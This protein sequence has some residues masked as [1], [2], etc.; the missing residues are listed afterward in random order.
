MYKETAEPGKAQWCVSADSEEGATN[1]K[2]YTNDNNEVYPLYTIHNKKTKRTTAF[3]ANPHKL[4]GNNEGREMTDESD[5][6]DQ[7]DLLEI[8]DEQDKI[9]SPIQL[10]HANT[11]LKDTH[12]G[13]FLFDHYPNSTHFVNADRKALE[14]GLTHTDPF[15]R[16]LA[17][18][19]P[20]ATEDDITNALNDPIETVRKM[21]MRHPKA[22]VDHITKALKDSSPIVRAQ[23]ILHN[24]VTPKHISSVLDT[25]DYYDDD[26][27]DATIRKFAAQHKNASFGNIKQALFDPN[28]TVNMAASKNKN[29]SVTPDIINLMLTHD[30]FGVR[31]AGLEHG[32]TI[33]EGNINTAL[34]SN[35][36]Y[37][38]AKVFKH[39]LKNITDTHIT[40]G[41]QDENKMV[42]E[43]AQAYANLKYNKS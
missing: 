25:A 38:R 30:A 35:D 24:N 13:K 12:I 2:H 18:G 28:R 1:F 19:H 29:S 39:G 43:A 10:L 36:Q 32:D 41:L 3:V 31:H 26:P 16:E 37:L 9:V 27:D 23:A 7:N 21:A 15:M 5:A 6:V 17:I 33:T 34:E 22:T 20:D 42:R 14:K 4:D 11:S 40:K 8:R